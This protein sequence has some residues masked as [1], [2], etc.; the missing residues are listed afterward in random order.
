MKL[1]KLNSSKLVTVNISKYKIDW[2]TQRASKVQFAAKQF[3][4]PF[5]VNHLCLEECRIPGS[6]LRLDIVNLTKKIIIE[7]SPIQHETF[8]KFF[9]VNRLGWLKQIKKDYAKVEWAE[10]A[11]FKLVELLKEDLDCLSVGLF[12]E[13]FNIDL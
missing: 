4:K 12:K 5:W 3:L 10:K 13:K 11:G 6:L 8:N 1:P 7:V 2:D 9:H